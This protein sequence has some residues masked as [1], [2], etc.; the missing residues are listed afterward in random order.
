MKQA[1]IKDLPL[2][3]GLAAEF[4]AESAALGSFEIERFRTLWTELLSN[5]TGVIFMLT[6]DEK[7]VGVIGGVCY[8]EA[9][10]SNLV[11]QEFFIFVAKQHRGGAGFL[12]LL[13][14]FESWARLKGCSEM[15]LAHLFDLQPV[16]LK[17][18]YLRLGFREIE[19]SFSKTLVA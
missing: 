17:D 9:Y 12:K 14:S 16:R 15:R 2:L 19:T 10:N 13:R 4:Y 18:L 7:P 3:A 8:P 11:A 6:H 1:D 5:G